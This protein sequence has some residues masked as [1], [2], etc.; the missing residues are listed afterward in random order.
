MFFNLFECPHLFSLGKA[1]RERGG[2]IYEDSF[3]RN[4]KKS[5]LLYLLQ[6]SSSRQ[7]FWPPQPSPQ[8]Q[9]EGEFTSVAAGK[10]KSRGQE[11]LWFCHNCVSSKAKTRGCFGVALELLKEKDRLLPMLT[12]NRK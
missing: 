10:I 3:L 5:G 8:R 7:A 9:D 2:A 4:W 6:I 1:G 11:E 12:P